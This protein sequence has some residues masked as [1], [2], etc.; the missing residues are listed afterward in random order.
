MPPLR[1]KAG[2]TAKQRKTK[3][4]GTSRITGGRGV[5]TRSIGLLGGIFTHAIDQGMRAENPLRG[6]R[7]F[8]ENKRERRLS[9]EEY[10]ALGSGLRQAAATIW[11]PAVACLRFLTVTG[12]AH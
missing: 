11:P 3:P 1:A 8:A 4:R 5:A 6:V 10:A 2:E 7:R 9:D 12:L